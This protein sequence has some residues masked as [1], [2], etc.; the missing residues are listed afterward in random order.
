M[1]SLLGECEWYQLCMSGSFAT[2]RCPTNGSGIRKMFN[3]LTNNCTDSIK[4]NI[5]NK[6]NSYKE[7][8]VMDQVS[9]FGKWVETRCESDQQYF[10]FENQKCM[11]IKNSTCGNFA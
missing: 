1:H 9:P 7:C 5:T 2:R 3:P 10:D 8:L 11:D 4:L 6:C